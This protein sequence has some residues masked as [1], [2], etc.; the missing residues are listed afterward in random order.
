MINEPIIFSGSFDVLV[1]TFKDCEVPDEWNESEPCFIANCQ[2]VQFKPFSTSLHRVDTT[3]SY[4]GD[5]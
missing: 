2:Q 1:Y 4:K 5:F 3:V